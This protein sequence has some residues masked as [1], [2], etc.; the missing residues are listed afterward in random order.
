MKFIKNIGFLFVLI[1][2]LNS[3]SKDDDDSVKE[4]AH[5][6]FVLVHGAW[7]A[8]FVWDKVKAA[9]ESQG[10]KV[11]KVELLGHGDDQTPVSEITFDGYVKQVTDV[12]D[13]L[14]TPV[15]LVGHSLGGAIITQ[16]ATIAPQ[17]IE[18]LV[19][20][21]GFIPQSG[22]SVFDYSA[23]DSGTLIPSVLEFSSDGNTV[24]IA[25]PEVNMRDVF[26][27][28]GSDEDIDLLVEK[29]RPEPVAAAGTPLNYN[30]DVYGTI[31]NKYYIYTTEDKAISYPF[32][33]QMVNEAHITKTYKIESGHSPFLSKPNE[34]VQLLNQITQQ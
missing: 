18:K 30:S 5:S 17:K 19:Y 29:L 10:N 2:T 32:Q 15:V 25:D 8:S 33:Q 4:G 9:L 24:T 27:Q 20:V 34:L 3:C 26:C 21:A 11:I 31:A 7:Q 12:I 22:S 28:Y 14:N 16:A 6:T 1:L 23:M 13:G